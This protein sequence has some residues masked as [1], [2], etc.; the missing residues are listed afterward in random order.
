MGYILYS[1]R[2]TH[3]HSLHSLALLTVVRM[4][5]KYDLQLGLCC[6]N[7]QLRAQK[8]PVFA[9]RGI[10]LKTV[11]KDGLAELKHRVLLNL[12]D[13]LTILDWNY[14]NNIHVYR[15]SSDMFP[16]MANPRLK[17][18]LEA[19]G[20]A[21]TEPDS[22][23]AYTF[24][25]A[26][27]LLKQI[28]D[29]ARKLKQ[30]LTFHPGQYNVLG[31]PNEQTLQNTIS[32]LLY[33]ATVMDLMG[34]DQNSVM[35]IHGSGLYGN[36]GETMDRWCKNYT[37]LPDPIKRR[38]V[39]ENCEKCYSIADCLTISERT[40]VPVVFDTHHHECYMLLHPHTRIKPAEYYIP[41]ILATWIR[42][43]IKPKFHV[44]EQAPGARVGKHS[45]F[46]DVIPQYLLDIPDKY[47]IPIDI[48]IEAKKKELAIDK[49]H[50]TYPRLFQ[51][52]LRKIS[53]KRS[54]KTLTIFI[55]ADTYTIYSY[56]SKRFKLTSSSLDEFMSK[57]GC[58]DIKYFGF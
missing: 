23:F 53:V 22:P 10:I 35:V 15:M 20:K 5:T 45:D 3:S 33:H 2:V 58:I 27:P 48:M 39:L 1:F 18:M 32:E 51:K 56:N 24:Y 49:L 36:K 52:P 19:T 25:F 44:S 34:L 13:V 43:G 4:A 7:T 11:E 31:T 37:E 14:A 8:P 57:L 47:H 26:K 54:G 29:K 6:I 12:Q 46:I 28:G 16:H 21:E 17:A 42:R 30:R 50:K 9:S 55:D 38:L 41:Q 40:G